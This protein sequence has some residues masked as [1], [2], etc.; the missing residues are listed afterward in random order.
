MSTWLETLQTEI[1]DELKSVHL[2]EP[3]TDLGAD[4]RIVGDMDEQLRGVYSL[5]MRWMKTAADNATAAQFETN[6]ERQELL[7]EQAQRLA[8]KSKILLDIFWISIKEQFDL[9]EKPSIGVR[10]GCKVVWSES[11]TPP[12]V[13]LFRRLFGQEE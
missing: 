3:N 10:R 8:K 2:M 13:D 4:D 9:W 7:S 6:K 1:Q 12:I 5:A 11:S